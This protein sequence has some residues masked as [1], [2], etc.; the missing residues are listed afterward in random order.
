MF[1]SGKNINLQMRFT[2]EQLQTIDTTH[3]QSLYN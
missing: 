2:R 3:Q 1:M